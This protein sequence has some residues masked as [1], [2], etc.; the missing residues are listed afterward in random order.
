MYDRAP[1]FKNQFF[2]HFQFA[3]NVVFGKGLEE[4]K[5]VTYK[6]ISFDAPKFSIDTEVLNQ[7]NKRRIVPTKINF[8]PCNVTW[9]D[10]KDAQVQR[11]WNFVYKFY[12]KDGLNKDP[13]NYGNQA[14][15][16]IVEGLYAGASP[17]IHSEFGY[18]LGNKAETHKLFRY[19][20][21]Y[22]VANMKYT[23]IDLVNPYMVSM[24]GDTFSQDGHSEH[25]TINATFTPETVVYVEE[26][27]SVKNEPVLS[28]LLGFGTGSPNTPNTS[29]I[30]NHYKQDNLDPTQNV[31]SDVPIPRSS[32]MRTDSGFGKIVPVTG[33]K[34]SK[35]ATIQKDIP[36]VGNQP[37][38]PDDFADMPMSPIEFSSKWSAADVVE[39]EAILN[40]VNPGAGMPKPSMDAVAKQLAGQLLSLIHI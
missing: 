8:D 28:G 25:A 30:L 22:L 32:R 13:I 7:Y 33:L 15:T 35:D 37:E 17:P 5:G 39:M 1:R 18:H 26:N 19:I 6:V 23:R 16:K 20:S 27:E 11:F 29:P 31:V 12:F 14:S 9:H 21:L 36:I 24:A 4:L 2:V 10:T 34:P 3:P 38:V 40:S